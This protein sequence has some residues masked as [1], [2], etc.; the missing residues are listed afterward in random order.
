MADP[1]LAEVWARQ[2]VP[3]RRGPSLRGWTPLVSKLTDLEDQVIALRATMSSGGSDVTF[4]ERPVPAYV[5]VR[6]R[7]AREKRTSAL[8]VLLPGQEV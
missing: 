2:P 6:E 5:A 4:S 3:K 8:S 1:D 7:I